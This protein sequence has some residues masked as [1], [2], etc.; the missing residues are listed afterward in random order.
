M[1]SNPFLGEQEMD[2]DLKRAIEDLHVVSLVRFHTG[3]KTHKSGAH[4]NLRCSAAS[5]H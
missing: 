1:F 2:E 4:D 5:S 3:D